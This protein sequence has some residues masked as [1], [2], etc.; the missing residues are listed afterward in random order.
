MSDSAI[1]YYDLTHQE[2]RIYY[3]D[4]ISSESNLHN[5]GGYLKINTDIDT[6]MMK[7]SINFL[8]E[9]NETL[10]IRFAEV[11][12]REVKYVESYENEIVDYFDFG[13]YENPIETCEI[14][15]QDTFNK[16]FDLENNKLYYFAIF[17]LSD[18]SYGVLL[19][20][21]HI[22]SD[23]WSIS[24]IQKRLCHIYTK[25][26]KREEIDCSNFHS[27]IDYLEEEK[28]YLNSERFKKNRE[29]W[30]QRFVTIP[31]DF[32]YKTSDTLVGNRLTF[33]LK[34]DL[35]D[36]IRAY[37]KH[38][39]YSL[40][41]FFVFAQIIYIYKMTAIKD[42]VIGVPVFNRTNG[43]QKNTI[44]MFTSS[45]PF[46]FALNPNDTIERVLK[47]VDRQLK[48][49]FVNQKYPYD[50]LVKDL[51]LS[52]K[53]YDSLYQMSV[54]YYNS[55]FETEI[56][57]V[58]VEVFEHYCGNQSYSMQL[59]I[60]NMKNDNIALKFDYKTDEYDKYY[61]E[62]MYS[63]LLNIITCMLDH[64]EMQIKSKRYIK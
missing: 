10:R 57:N 52:T 25:L 14:W 48:V 29:F 45:M 56:E 44:G 34:H 50:L 17:K 28:Q 43:K 37:I 24:L 42:I 46:R 32:L 41:T 8:I 5:I 4:K 11:Q 3:I 35:S 26:L 18:Q 53:G 51:G 19:N 31:E 16:R 21:H 38:N 64:Q 33:E 59:I 62:A 23:G 49:C 58:P 6:E 63:Y 36:R 39:N 54:N 20:I 61:V 55:K 2:K 60:D 30:K 27:Y 1:E 13:I 7:K 47:S 12:G 40:N 15:M 9:T 22:I